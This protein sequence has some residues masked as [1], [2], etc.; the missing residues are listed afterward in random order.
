MGENLLGIIEYINA[1]I[2]FSGCI[3]VEEIDDLF[4]LY[5]ILEEEKSIVFE[6]LEK[7]NVEIIYSDKVFR[8]KLFRLYNYISPNREVTDKKIE[9]WAKEESISNYMRNKVIQGLGDCGYKIILDTYN[10]RLNR[11]V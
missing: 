9:K 8:E 3:G 5:P 7:L 10:N 2:D 1:S 11:V 4:E 6:K